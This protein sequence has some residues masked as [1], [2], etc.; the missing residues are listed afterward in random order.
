MVT[1]RHHQQH[2]ENTIEDICT[3]MYSIKLNSLSES[4]GL[5]AKVFI[6]EKAP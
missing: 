5:Q 2:E 6:T 4:A 3:F 1:I